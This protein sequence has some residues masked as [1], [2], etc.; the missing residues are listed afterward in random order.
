MLRRRFSGM[1]FK[2]HCHCLKH[3]SWWI[4]QLRGLNFSVPSCSGHGNRSHESNSPWPWSKLYKWSSLPMLWLH[5]LGEMN[6]LVMSF[7]GIPSW[8]FQWIFPQILIRLLKNVAWESCWR[9]RGIH[10]GTFLD[11]WVCQ[12]VNFFK[13]VAFPLSRWL[14]LLGHTALRT[15]QLFSFASIEDPQVS[16]WAAEIWIFFSVCCGAEPT[17]F[18]LSFFVIFSQVLLQLFSGF[19]PL[20][21]PVPQCFFALSCLLSRKVIYSQKLFSWKHV[22]WF[23]NH[24]LWHLLSSTATFLQLGH[25]HEVLTMLLDMPWVNNSIISIHQ[26]NGGKHQAVRVSVDM[27]PWCQR[28]LSRKQ[29]GLW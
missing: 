25:D 14:E 7:L 23:A 29:D 12:H 9:L 20:A 19:E 1:P 28:L 4:L 13:M 17:M 15:I 6:Q 3:L 22:C 16:N 24:P 18:P 21:S 27:F 10:H 26:Q 11:L 8:T 2:K 5:R